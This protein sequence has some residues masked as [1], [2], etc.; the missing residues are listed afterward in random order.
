MQDAQ[1]SSV[2]VLTTLAQLTLLSLLLLR[3]C[4]NNNIHTR[5][6]GFY[7]TTKAGNA[8][9]ALKAPLKPQPHCKRD[10]KW[11]T[12]ESGG[13]VPGDLV[14]LGSG[15]AVPADCMVSS[16]TCHYC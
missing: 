15:G 2:R 1:Y 7:E 13:L 3:Y 12:L 10:G 14:L 16:V 4:Y 11:V 8:V 6:T 9:A 5:H